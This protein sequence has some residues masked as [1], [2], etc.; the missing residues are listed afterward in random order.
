MGNCQLSFALLPLYASF[1]GSNCPS[2]GVLAHGAS[3]RPVCENGYVLNGQYTCEQG[4]WTSLPF[5]TAESCR[6]YPPVYGSY[7]DCPNILPIRSSCVPAC[8]PGYSV[9]GIFKCEDFGALTSSAVC[10]PNGC[11]LSAPANGELG[12]KCPQ[13]SMLA[14]G[15][16]C[17][18]SCHSGFLLDGLFYCQSGVL[19]H[20]ASCL[21]AASPCKIAP[22]PA[23]FPGNCPALDPLAHGATC[24]PGCNPGY[25]L[26]GEF[27]CN[28]GVLTSIAS[29]QLAECV[30]SAPVGG[31]LGSCPSVLPTG[32]TCRPSCQTGYLLVG[33]FRCENGNITSTAS[34]QEEDSEP[35]SSYDNTFSYDA[36][37]NC[38]VLPPS[39]G[40]LGECWLRLGHGMSCKPRCDRG[41]E[42]RG[43]F[44][45]SYG[46]LRKN[47]TCENLQTSCTLEP[48]AYGSLGHCLRD[49]PHGTSCRPTCSP[50][51]QVDGMF[52]CL[53]GQLKRTATCLADAGRL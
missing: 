31:D 12:D 30:L 52:A 51:F 9:Q 41:Y 45:C 50:G 42:L 23:S 43:Q 10:F 36:T 49:L 46:A 13:D 17:R 8:E 28:A 44:E 25:V 1:V 14:H 22:P 24:Q 2:M 19:T 47:A 4:I 33:E 38:F 48:P 5:C 18:P 27:T 32:G 3:C 26:N 39:H 21:P 11:R 37:L 16:S 53:S 6:V 40:S 15:E 34:C 35:S 7:G 20:T 29:C